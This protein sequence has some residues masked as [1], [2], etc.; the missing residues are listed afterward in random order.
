MGKPSIFSKD[1][2]RKMKRRKFKILFI[3]LIV[4]L[5]VG[6]ILCSGY[7]SN[8][9]Q[10]TK[11]QY[12]ADKQKEEEKEKEV[13]DKNKDSSEESSLIKEEKDIAKEE[14]LYYEIKLTDDT[15]VKLVY[16]GK[17]ENIKYKFAETDGNKI[18]FDINPSGKKLLIYEEGTQ[19]LFIYDT[20]G[21]YVDGTMKN[22]TSG[23]AGKTF[24]KDTEL[25]KNPSYIW[26]GMPKFYS[27]TQIAFISQLPWFGKEDKYIWTLD[28][29]AK[30]YNNTNIQGRNIII[31]GMQDKG[32]EISLDGVLNYMTKDGNI[33]Q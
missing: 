33:V 12:L 16:E 4:A 5:V 9:I 7:I 26:C 15:I 14:Q 8:F 27:D 29:D 17:D 22:F 6:T 10:E 28:L 18:Y 24:D 20:N 19:N 30:S 32:L 31:N 23:S 1:Y 25:G 11:K 13:L 2:E 3:G 21:N